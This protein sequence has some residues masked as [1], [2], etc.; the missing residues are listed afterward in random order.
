[1]A[2]SN[3]SSNSWGAAAT[4]IA[5]LATGILGARTARR[6]TDA[7]IKANRELAEYQYEKDLEMWERQNAYNDPSMQMA[8]LKAAGLNPNLVYGDKGVSGNW[9]APGPKY[10][11]PNVEYQYQNPFQNL[12]SAV[13][14]YQD[15][16]LRQAQIDNVNAQTANTNARTAT[17]SFNTLLR[18]LQVEG[19]T[20][21]TRVKQNLENYQYQIKDAELSR[22]QNELAVQLE[23]IKMM[24]NEQQLQALEMQARQRGLTNAELET[25]RREAELLFLQYKNE[26]MKHGVTSGDHPILRMLIRAF[27][28]GGLESVIPDFDINRKKIDR[29]LNV[30]QPSGASTSW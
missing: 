15:M 7:T 26:W 6:N 25:E 10:Q 13:A 3:S 17:E 1:M 11:A 28:S 24:S 30:N 29:D 12:G 8:R 19:E 16:R 27:N 2:E 9:S 14:M 18:G 4:P 21:D 22:A 23:R 20:V 5:G